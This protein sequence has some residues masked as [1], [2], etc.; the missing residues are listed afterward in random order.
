MKCVWP[1]GNLPED[2]TD[3]EL[4]IIGLKSPAQVTTVLF[5]GICRFVSPAKQR[6]TVSA[7]DLNS[8]LIFLRSSLSIS[9][10]LVELRMA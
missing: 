3:L 6:D 4:D 9:E 7:Q 1:A 2:A 10:M 8:L 5:E